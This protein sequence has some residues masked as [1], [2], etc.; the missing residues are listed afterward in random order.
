LALRI[1]GKAG[2]VAAYLTALGDDIEIT[3]S[4]EQPPAA[5]ARAKTSPGRSKAQ[6]KKEA[7]VK[8]APAKAASV[9]AASDQAC[10]IIGCDNPVRSRGYCAAHYQKYNNLKKTG[11]AAE[12]GWTD[13][14]PPQ[15]VTNPTLPRGRAGAQAKAVAESD[16]VDSAPEE[17]VVKAVPP[18]IRRAGSK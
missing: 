1:S 4:I 7:A 15:S 14:A 8:E 16:G 12:Y 10:A 11:R 9:K 17:K 2:E 6:P 18:R 5:R 13:D 3:I